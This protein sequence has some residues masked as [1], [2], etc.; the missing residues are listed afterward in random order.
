MNRRPC[1]KFG[2]WP[3]AVGLIWASVCLELPAA[4]T[5]SA[6][7]GD[8]WTAAFGLDALLATFSLEGS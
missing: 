4:L 3:L 5:N 2:G 6:G 7:F 8:C 1:V